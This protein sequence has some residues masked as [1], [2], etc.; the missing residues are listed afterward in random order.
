MKDSVVKTILIV[1][2]IFSRCQW[3]STGL[4]HIYDSG[5]W[6]LTNQWWW[7]VVYRTPSVDGNR[8]QGEQF[9]W[10][11]VERRHTIWWSRIE[12]FWWSWFTTVDA[13]GGVG[14]EHQA[15]QADDGW[16]S[17]MIDGLCRGWSSHCFHG[18]HGA[19]RRTWFTQH[20]TGP[21]EEWMTYSSPLRSQ[22][23]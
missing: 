7:P 18:G 14:H 17:M 12:L 13:G 16:L 10:P 8:L 19:S 5:E 4:C 3:W 1:C 9:L 21:K 15:W 22:E 23:T 6:W 11:R 20:P 2:A